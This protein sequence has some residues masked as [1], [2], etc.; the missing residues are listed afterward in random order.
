MR[1]VYHPGTSS[2]VSAEKRGANLGHLAGRQRAWA[3]LTRV[4]IEIVRDFL[5]WLHDGNWDSAASVL[6]VFISILGFALTLIQVARSKNAAERAEEA[7][8][9]ARKDLALQSVAIDL[10]TLTADIE[11]MKQLH[12]LGYW[13]VMPIRYG[14]VRR[15]LIGIRANAQTLTR[16]QKSSILGIIE[17]FKDIE[18]VVEEAITSDQPPTDVAGLNKLASEQVDKLTEVL[19]AVQQEIK[20]R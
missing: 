20:N 19:V 18:Q 10:T 12:R 5:K 3:T 13:K 4:R 8:A 15:K 7:V 14:A 6:G 2:Q 9:D 1:P 11:E 17:Q 16:A